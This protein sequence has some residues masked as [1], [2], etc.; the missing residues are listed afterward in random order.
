MLR[1]ACNKSG[2]VERKNGEKKF[3]R[4]KKNAHR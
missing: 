1:V 2:A 4:N 3:E